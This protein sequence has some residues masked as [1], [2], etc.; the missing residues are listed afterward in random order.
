M[1]LGDSLLEVQYFLSFFESMF[2]NY[3]QIRGILRL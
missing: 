3:A 1:D 2:E